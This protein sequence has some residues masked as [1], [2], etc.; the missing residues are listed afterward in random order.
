MAIMNKSSVNIQVQVFMLTRIS[1]PL[2]KY[3][4]MELLD[5]MISIYFL[6]LKETAALVSRVVVP[7]YPPN[8]NV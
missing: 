1:F 6:T 7:F 5:H 4:E 3:L 2:G 8:R